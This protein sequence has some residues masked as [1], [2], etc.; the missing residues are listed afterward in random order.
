M[1]EAHHL[2]PFYPS[3]AILMD[4]RSFG[5]TKDNI[6]QDQTMFLIEIN[7]LLQENLPSFV[8]GGMA[9][10]AQSIKLSLAL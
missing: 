5:T 10:I 4:T 2:V 7:S 9:K 8:K 6:N 1:N 3:S